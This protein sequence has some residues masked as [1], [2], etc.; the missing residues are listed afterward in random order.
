LIKLKKIRDKKILK[1]Q[2]IINDLSRLDKSEEVIISG[3]GNGGV[4]ISQLSFL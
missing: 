3:I 1:N 4:P 2:R